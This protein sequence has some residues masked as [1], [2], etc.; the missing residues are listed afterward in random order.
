MFKV[1][2]YKL[3]YN[4][5]RIRIRKKDGDEAVK[6]VI[7]EFKSEYDKWMV[8]RNKADLREIEEYKKVF[9]T[10]FVERGKREEERENTREESRMGDERG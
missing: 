7:I 6:P 5:I 8:L 10:G 9:R 1:S 2:T 4:I 3:I